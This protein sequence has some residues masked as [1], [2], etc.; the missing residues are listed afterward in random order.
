[1]RSTQRVASGVAPFVLVALVALV[2]PASMTTAGARA[3]PSAASV[4]SA[5]TPALDWAACPDGSP[6]AAAGFVCATASVP[7][8][9]GAP[10]GPQINL[11][12]VKHVATGPAPR[13]GTLFVNPGGPGGTGTAQIPGWIHFVPA[14]V[15]ERF[16]IV[17]WDP[18]GI[19]EST[20][21]QCFDTADDEGAFLG[22]SANFP[23]G[24][25]QQQAHIATWKAFGE[26]CLNREG[27]LLE[28]VSTG[29]TARDLDQ[30]REAVGDPTLTYLGLSYGTFL[31]ATYANLFPDKVRALVLDGNLAPDA[32]TAGGDPDPALGISLR[33]GSDVGAST[34]LDALLTRCGLAPTATCPF[35]A[36]TP[37]STKAKFN[38]LFDRLL[39]GPITIGSGQSSVSVTYAELLTQLSDALDIVLPYKNVDIPSQSIPGWVGAAVVLQE[40]WN[41]SGLQAGSAMAGAGAAT[42][43]IAPSAVEPYAGPEQA[44]SVICGDSPNPGNPD[45]YVNL[46]DDVLGRDG[47][48]G[49]VALW[50]D[51]PC[52]AWPAHTPAGYPGP[53]NTPTAHPILVI[54][55]TNDPSTPYSGSVKMA[56]Q[57]ANVRLLTVDG[58]GH[59]A[60][61]NPST[62]ANNY[63]AAYLIDGVL[64]AA[65][66]VCQQDVAPFAF[67]PATNPTP[68]VV[69]PTFTG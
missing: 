60:F 34:D 14:T 43:A 21:I 11:A 36:G 18:R 64:P 8:D 57:L 59:T 38:A 19:G 65:G 31:G 67:A 48:I 1:M 66:T 22:E 25:V 28:H 47:P 46:V 42:T 17:S 56:E 68:V 44:L 5:V 6:G 50:A 16:D 23:V 4:G 15:L 27:N 7:L 30:L 3:A 24:T 52:A 69:T 12:V 26:Q 37:E 63:A 35:S 61:L 51:E 58:Y 33:V 49:L 20:S 39:A 45:T 2:A 55:N 41:A 54:G 62:C 13:V 29:E 53:W 32:W 9:Y 40:L 10:A